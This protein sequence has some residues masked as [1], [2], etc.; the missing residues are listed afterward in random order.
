MGLVAIKEGECAHAVY[1]IDGV[2]YRREHAMFLGAL[3]TERFREI[4]KSAERRYVARMSE[5]AGDA[6]R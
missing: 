3:D 5:E 6:I 4:I 2:K 1:E